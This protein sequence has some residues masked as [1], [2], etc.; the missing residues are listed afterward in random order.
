VTPQDFEVMITKEEFERISEALPVLQDAGPQMVR[1]FLANAYYARLPTNHDVF[2][3]GDHADAIALLLSGQVRVYKIGE[4][5]REITLYRFGTGESCVL[6]ANA[7]L[8]RQSFP[9]LAT[10]ESDAEAIMIPAEVFRDW[11]DRFDPWRSFFFDLLAQRLATM[12]A[13]VDEVTFRRLDVRLARLLSQRGEFQ[14]P[15]AVTHHELASELGSSREVIS[16]LLADFAEEG[17]IKMMRGEI[18]IVDS[19]ALSR[20]GT[21]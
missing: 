9:A 13:V 12:L 15:I 3:E 7:I 16:R 21:M 17:L 19:E 10:V 5:G 11:I 2:A 4:N 6:T 8:S 18:E 14:N 1:E 20:R